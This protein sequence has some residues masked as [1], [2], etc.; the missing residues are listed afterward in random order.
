MNFCKNFAFPYFFAKFSHFLFREIFAFFAR[1]KNAK[2]LQNDFLF[3]V[4]NPV[5]QYMLKLCAPR[6]GAEEV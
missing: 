2:F 4:G 1:E 6:I 5:D 3:F